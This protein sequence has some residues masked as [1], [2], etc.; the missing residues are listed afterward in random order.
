MDTCES[1]FPKSM[2]DD[3]FDA[4]FSCPSIRNA[5]PTSASAREGASLI[6][7]PTFK[8]QLSLALPISLRIVT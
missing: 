7:S 1:L 2:I 3:A 4:A 5:I 8:T 6:P